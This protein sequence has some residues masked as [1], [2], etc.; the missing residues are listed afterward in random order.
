MIRQKI[1]GGCAVLGALDYRLVQVA[2]ILDLAG[3]ICGGWV[4]FACDMHVSR[5]M[6]YA[7]SC[8]INVNSQTD[9]HCRLLVNKRR[10][11]IRIICTSQAARTYGVLRRQGQTL[12]ACARPA[13][14]LRP[15]C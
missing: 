8:R 4:E 2:S 14:F 3:S 12:A 13:C 7:I 6:K 5:Y 11:L 1:I 15:A 10:R 9:T